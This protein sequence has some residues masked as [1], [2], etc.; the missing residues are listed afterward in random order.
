MSCCGQGRSQLRDGVAPATRTTTLVFEYVGRT[1]LV[2]TGSATRMSYR[3]DQPG[4][5]VL[6]DGRDRL[7][8]ASVP[9]LRQVSA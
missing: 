5:R 7:S 9:V 2:V 6:V 4:A 1:R 8:L 3:F